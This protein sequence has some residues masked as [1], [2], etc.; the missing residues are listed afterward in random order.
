MNKIK[1]SSKRFLQFS[2]GEWCG[3]IILLSLIF[4]TYAT[5]FFLPIQVDEAT[6]YSEFMEEISHF[7]NEQQRIADSIAWTRSQRNYRQR[8]YS[9]RRN[10]T[11]YGSKYQR[12]TISQ[13]PW[14]KTEKRLG[15]EIIKLDINTCDSSDIMRVPQFGAKR[16]KKVIEY[17]VRL[18]GFYSLQQIKEIY[19]LQ[20]IDEELLSK[21]FVVNK[22][23]IRKINVNQASYK[24]MISHPYFD[25][26]LTKTILN[27]R[28]KNGPI[29]SVDEFK[30]ITNAYPE[31]MDKLTPYLSF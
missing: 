25:V 7:Q 24:E 14:S 16:A 30:R 23:H 2:R 13:K 19:I 8:N 10:T 15:Y 18:G 31:L 9:S 12:D 27:H 3:I 17:R 26:Y 28:Q 22:H 5:V 20:N 4:I 11:Y 1:N 21:Y 6:D 29:R